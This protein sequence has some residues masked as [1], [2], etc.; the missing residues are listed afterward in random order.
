MRCVRQGSANLQPAV[1]SILHC[2]LY[3]VELNAQPVNADL[4]RAVAKFIDV[5]MHD[6]M[7]RQTFFTH[8]LRLAM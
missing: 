6:Y 3:Y 7:R 1:L 4:L 8:L 2:M 5:C